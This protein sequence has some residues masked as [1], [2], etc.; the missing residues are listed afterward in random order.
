VIDAAT[1]AVSHE[2]R[3]RNLIDAQ[4]AAGALADETRRD[5]ALHATFT[6]DALISTPVLV[7]YIAF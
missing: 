6:Q 7:Q 2:S 5:D 3:V 1:P 4:I